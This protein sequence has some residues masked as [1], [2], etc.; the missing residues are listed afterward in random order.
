[1]ERVYN[2]NNSTLR[3]VFGDIIESKA[4]V[5]VSSDDALL[6]MGGGV[7]RAIMC[8]AGHQIR[9]EVSKHIPATIGDVVVTGAFNMPQKYIFHAITISKETQDLRHGER[10]HELSKMQK[11]ILRNSVDK[12]C[13]LLKDLGL[14]SIA[15]PAIGS[16]VARIPLETVAK[17]MAEALAYN[18]LKTE[19]QYNIE[20]YLYDC[21]G[22]FSQMDYLSFF[23]Q[24]SFSI[25]EA[26]YRF[27]VEK[28]QETTNIICFMAGS[29]A[30]EQERDAF[31]AIVSKADNKW[32]SCNIK[33]FDYQDFKRAYSELGHQQEYNQFIANRTDFM[34]FV[35]TGNMGDKTREELETA[36]EAYG[37]IKR[38]EIVIYVQTEAFDNNALG[39]GV[40]EW[41][42][43]KKIYCVKYEDIK[44]LK[45]KVSEDL[46]N[47][48]IRR[49]GK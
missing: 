10:P 13:C 42:D 15:F 1:M 24:I 34:I 8:A 25:N 14:S 28:A 5:V 29:I 44:D 31:R 32:V 20:L 17:E 9:H 36:A 38:P 33:S 16:G 3:V 27:T 40:M 11:F 37:R 12:C 2:I 7:S 47:Y 35:L 48:I 46:D 21:Y 19:N 6:T 30:L 23:E 49:F 39:D 18:L 26:K 4:E 22:I 41:I 45:Y 43:E